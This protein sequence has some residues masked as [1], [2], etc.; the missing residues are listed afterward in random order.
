MTAVSCHSSHNV[1][2]RKDLKLKDVLG[3]PSTSGHAASA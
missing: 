2:P 3:A 1:S